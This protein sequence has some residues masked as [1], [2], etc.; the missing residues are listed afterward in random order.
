MQTVKLNDIF[1]IEYGNQLDFNK[2]EVDENSEINFV[3]RTSKNLGVVNQVKNIGIDPYPAGLITVTLG[4]SYLLSSF[5]QP[6]PFYTAQNIKVLS[7][8][9]RMTFGEKI[10]YCKCI[11][12]NR[13]KYTSH[14][15]EANKTLDYLN[16]PSLEEIPTNLKGIDGA[17]PIDNKSLIDEDINLEIEK[18]KWFKYSDLFV[19]KRGKGP[20]KKNLLEGGNTPLVTS[21]DENNGVSDYTRRSPNH[22]ANVITVNRNG[23][24][25]EAFYQPEAFSSTEDVH[26][27]I[28]KFELNPYVALF[29]VTLIKMEKYRFSYGRKW[30]IKRMNES[31]IL[32]PATEDGSIDLSFME[33]F[34]KSIHYS[35][36]IE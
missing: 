27:F 2:M 24:V 34:I 10:F 26:V 15:R 30:G 9:T 5:V 33:R 28:P 36:K 3:S 22:K 16:V 14:G 18:W 1:D 7:P 25:G 8:K 17:E 20:R 21:T 12:F 32:L 11:E 6:K 13:F 19:I 23:S 31:K 29:L 4:G 35:S